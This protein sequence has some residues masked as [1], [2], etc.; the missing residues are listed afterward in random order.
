MPWKF[1]KVGAWT[2]RCQEEVVLLC[3][4]W[5]HPKVRDWKEKRRP[6]GR[7]GEECSRPREAEMGA[8]SVLEA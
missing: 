8:V 5:S 1:K 3:G 4:V 2:S 7:L 6:R